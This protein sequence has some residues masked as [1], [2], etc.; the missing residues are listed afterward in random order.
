MRI[1]ESNLRIIVKRFGQLTVNICKH[2]CHPVAHNFNMSICHTLFIPQLTIQ[3]A[4][5]YRTEHSSSCSSKW[6]SG[7]SSDLLMWEANL[8]FILVEHSRFPSHVGN[9]EYR[10][11]KNQC[12]LW[13][14]RFSDILLPEPRNCWTSCWPATIV[15]LIV[16]PNS[17]IPSG[18]NSFNCVVSK[19][20]LEYCSIWQKGA[21][22]MESGFAPAWL[23]SWTLSLRISRISCCVRELDRN[24]DLKKVNVPMRNYNGDSR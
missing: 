17:S 4:G 23:L 24:E 15:L 11:L 7:S 3:P 1:K 5:L 19:A 18:F 13:V 21:L 8:Y 16:D 20:K 12:F 10:L 6:S 2:R 9:I 22:I 14:T